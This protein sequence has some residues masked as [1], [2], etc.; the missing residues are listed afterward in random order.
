MKKQRR[1][2]TPEFKL[3]AASLVLDQGYSIAEACQS[4]GIGDTALRRW[5]DQLRA[6]RGGETPASKAMTPEQKRIQELEARIKRLE[7]EKDILKKASASSTGPRKFAL[8]L[9]GRC[10]VVEC[11]P[12]SFIQLPCKFI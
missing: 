7:Q 10:Q 2:F 4:L 9:L 3:E 1:S 5:V 6:E 8:Q 12:R 11:F